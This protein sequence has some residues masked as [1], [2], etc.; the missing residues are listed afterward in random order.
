[1]IRVN[2]RDILLNADNGYSVKRKGNSIMFKMV[3]KVGDR[4]TISSDEVYI[5]S[6][7]LYGENNTDKNRE[8]AVLLAT[9]EKLGYIEHQDTS[10][11]DLRR[12]LENN[13]ERIPA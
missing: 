6:P 12:F 8:F 13:L 11:V 3:S 1:M 5:V 9:A 4:Y 10:I 2:W 7:R